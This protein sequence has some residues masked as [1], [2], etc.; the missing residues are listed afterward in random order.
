MEL[1]KTKEKSLIRS[2]SKTYTYRLND[3]KFCNND[4]IM[5]LTMQLLLALRIE[6]V[7][8]VLETV[9]QKFMLLVR[10]AI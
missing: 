6:I 8:L 10:C 1:L 4:V 9:I 7:S 5:S 3:V 2:A